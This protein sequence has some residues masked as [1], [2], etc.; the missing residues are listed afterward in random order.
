MISLCCS[1][2]V[3]VPQGHWVKLFENMCRWHVSPLIMFW[4]SLLKASLLI[5]SFRFGEERGSL[6]QNRHIEDISFPLLEFWWLEIHWHKNFYPASTKPPCTVETLSEK[7]GVKDRICKIYSILILICFPL[8]LNSFTPYSRGNLTFSVLTPEPNHRP[9]Y[10]DF[11]NT[12]SLQEFV[13]ATQVRIHLHG[14]YHTTEPWVN[15]RHRYYGVNEVT[16]S[17]R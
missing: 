1:S 14:Q 2:L 17:G 9:G 3:H 4:S 6:G 8:Y 5:G 10:N 11:Y 13:K 15:F 7:Q 16:V 12:P